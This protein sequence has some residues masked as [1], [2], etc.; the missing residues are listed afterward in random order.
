MADLTVVEPVEPLPVVEPVE[1]LGET[2]SKPGEVR[3]DRAGAR[4][5][6]DTAHVVR[7]LNRRGE[8]GR[9]RP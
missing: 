7:R 4:D 3:W 6:F 9:M 1:P 5:G 8:D 2:V